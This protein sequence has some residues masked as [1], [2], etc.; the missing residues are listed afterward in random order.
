MMIRGFT[1]FA[2]AWLLFTTTAC[3]GSGPIRPAEIAYGIDA[4]DYCH[5]SV[6]EPELTAQWVRADGRVHAFDEPGC[7]VAWLQREGEPAGAGFV[8]DADGD[9]WIPLAEAHYVRGGRQTT[10]GYDVIAFRDADAAA[11]RAEERDG[12]VLTW[13]ALRRE[14]VEHARSVD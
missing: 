11:G 13:D 7:L 9:G 8:A 6:D 3:A 2:A 12:M 1:A 4:C 14:G 5:M 10:M